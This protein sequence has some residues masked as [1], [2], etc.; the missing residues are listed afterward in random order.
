MMAAFLVYGTGMIRI[1]ALSLQP[2]A[3]CFSDNVLRIERIMREQADVDLFFCPDGALSGL[4][5]ASSRGFKGMLEE[6]VSHLHEFARGM[7]QEVLVPMDGAVVQ[8]GVGLA[9]PRV[10]CEGLVQTH[11]GVSVVLNDCASPGQ[12]EWRPFDLK[13]VGDVRGGASGRLKPARGAAAVSTNLLGG[14]SGVVYAGGCCAA[15]IDE[16]SELPFMT[17]GA[18]VADLE[19]ELSGFSM[20]SLNAPVEQEFSSIGL[21]H[22]ALKMGVSEYVAASGASG[23]VVGLSGGI[24]SAVS[25]ALAVECL[26]SNAVYGIALSS[27]YTSGESRD[28]VK[29]LCS[30]LGIEY[31]E[32][33]IESLHDMM[34]KNVEAEF[35][36]SL[37]GGITDQNIQARFRGMWLMALANERGALM[38]C[39]ANKSEC[40]MGYGT[41]YGDIAG[42]LAPLADLWKSEVWELA[43]EIN[44]KCG[45][46]VIPNEIINREPTAELYPG[47]KDTDSLPPYLEIEEGLKRAFAAEDIRSLSGSDKALLA[48]FL[49][50]S[51]K[52]AQSPLA[53]VV[54]DSPLSKF[55]AMWGLNRRI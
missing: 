54:S 47:Q 51:F 41:L 29:K 5:E 6:A 3:G 25:A 53:L 19:F 16:I 30:G 40:A 14:S 38:L 4:P 42:G 27:R 12:I 2:S 17:E 52:R 28:L 48:R 32:A 18:A 45:K 31:R 33:S 22:E 26:G 23:V 7:K 24:D 35:G 15:C 10:V 37:A 20:K 11:V 1:A 46:E 8:L 55:D 50:S 34:L 49:R 9:S 39:N 43:R 44:R 13:S 36:R 21:A